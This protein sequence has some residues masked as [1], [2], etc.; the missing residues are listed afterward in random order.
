MSFSLLARRALT[1]AVL[2]VAAT[3][4]SAQSRVWTVAPS[5]PA[6]FTEIQHAIDAAA[7]GDLIY[8]TGG[9]YDNLV[10]DGKG[11]T[12]V[13]ATGTG[14]IDHTPVFGQT[15]PAL[16]L[17]NIPAD[18]VC[19]VSGLQVFLGHIGPNSAVLVEDCPGT[20]WLQDLF[21][22]AYG[23]A[24]LRIEASN[25]VVTTSSLFQTNAAAALPDGTPQSEPGAWVL[26]GSRLHGYDAEFAGS[27]NILQFGGAPTPNAPSK[28]GDGLILSNSVASLSGG[29]VEGSRGSSLF[30]NG[31]QQGGDGGHGVHFL[32]D[33]SFVV[34]HS[35]PVT[36]GS[37]GQFDPGCATAGA[38]GQQVEGDASHAQFGTSTPRRLST[39]TQVS[40]GELLSLTLSGD[41]GDLGFLFIADTPAAAAPAAQITLHL[42]TSSLKLLTTLPM[43]SGERTLSLPVPALPAGLEGLLLPMQAAMLSSSGSRH[44]TGPRALAVL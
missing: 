23:A 19:I 43:P 42:D 31:C 39:P 3:S 17:R 27:H 2:F 28:G 9:G 22:D 30:V 6:D 33:D 14:L 40:P 7:S 24:A 18:E 26:D 35:T 8:V 21:V 15:Q 41:P 25:T 20:V 32:D 44:E 1:G 10:I 5:G 11:L 16:T 34:T 37:A 12:L 29:S 38:P 13:G 36:A 4:L